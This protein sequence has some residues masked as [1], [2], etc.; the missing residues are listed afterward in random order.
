[1]QAYV[2]SDTTL[3]IG[4]YYVALNWAYEQLT[5]AWEASEYSGDYPMLPPA[6]DLLPPMMCA[7]HAAHVVNFSEFLTPNAEYCEAGVGEAFT[8]ALYL[9]I[10][11]DDLTHGDF[12]L[13]SDSTQS[14]LE[15]W[16]VVKDAHYYCFDESEY[17]EL[18]EGV[19]DVWGVVINELEECIY[20]DCLP[21]EL[22]AAL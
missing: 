12:A 5:D 1:M 15:N 16:L 8:G 13:M 10:M 11:W 9:T 17:F 7:W 22:L 21:F 14:C 20:S 4:D 19:E 6:E 3:S 18:W 2:N